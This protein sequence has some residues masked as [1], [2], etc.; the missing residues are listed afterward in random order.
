MTSPSDTSHPQ[1]PQPAATASTT[2]AP[3]PVPA[4]APTMPAA[5]PVPL[6]EPSEA[7]PAPPDSK[8]PVGGGTGPSGLRR[9]GTRLGAG[10]RNTAA[11]LSFRLA[12][13]NCSAEELRRRIVLRQLTAHDALRETVDDELKHVRTRIA[14]LERAGI[15]DGWTPEQRQT[16]RQLRDER[17][18]REA[19]VKG[20]H[21]DQF[22]PVQPT[23]AQIRRARH[24]AATRRTIVFLALLAA[25]GYGV[26]RTPQLAVLL[27]V[28]VL[29]VV[30]W[31]GG[32]PPVLVQRPVPEHLLSR[33]ELAAPPAED[34]PAVPQGEDGETDLRGVVDPGQVAERV[35]WALTKQKIKVREVHSTTRTAWGWQSTV[36]LREGTSADIVKSLGDLVT[37]F[38]T[39]PGRTLAAGSPDDGAEVTLRVLMTDPFAAPPA[40]PVR[41]PRS[42]SIRDPFSPCISLDGESTEL[43]LPGTSVLVVAAPGGGKSVFV[44]SLADFATACRDAVVWDI[45]PTGR[46][47]GPLGA[48]AARRALTVEDAEQAL[49]DLVEYAERRARLLSDTQD[50]WD[51]T[52]LSPAIVAIV[53]EYH[54]LSKTGKQHAITLLRIARKARIPLVICTQDASQDVLSDA[55]ADSFGIRVMLPCRVDDVPLAVGRKNAISEGWLPHLLSPGDDTDPADAGRCYLFSPRHRTPILRYTIPL[56]AATALARATERAAAGLPQLD[57]ATTGAPAAAPPLPPFLALLRGFFA[58]EGD[59]EHLTVADLMEHLAAADPVRWTQWD[60]RKDRLTMGGKAIRAELA[61]VGCAATAVRINSLPGR[62]SAYL[63][64][65]LTTAPTPP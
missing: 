61:A 3:G 18:R 19:V 60:A 46:G 59:P 4:T 33:P 38:R 10:A 6:T 64:A 52:E 63:L 12:A 28:A 55:V 44:R 11:A 41:A 22:R 58:A 24:L 37:A 62:P 48:A 31:L 40:F 1:Q 17:K 21:A 2:K 23:E 25:L 65:D 16:I 30:W 51:V 5:P 50:Y 49:A 15:D 36:V 43:V 56:D 45:D 54:R 26:V 32:H 27:V 35:R 53:D 34:L 47:L 9:T 29:A 8:A 13:S 20:L 14:R 57:A 7:T 42:C 39:G